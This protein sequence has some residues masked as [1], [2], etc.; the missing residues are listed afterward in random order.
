MAIYCQ[1]VLQKGCTSSHSAWQCRDAHFLLCQH[2]VTGIDSFF[3]SL[4]LCPS[5]ELSGTTFVLTG[6]LHSVFCLLFELFPQFLYFLLFF[7]WRIIT[8]Q[9]CDAFC[10]TSPWTSH[11]YTYIPFLLNPIPLPS[12]P[13]PE[14]WLWAPCIRYQTPTGYLLNIW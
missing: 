1:N 11:R 3:F 14:D 2:W 5:D 12:L 7:N 10:H 4:V 6:D 13:H 8:L 9:Y